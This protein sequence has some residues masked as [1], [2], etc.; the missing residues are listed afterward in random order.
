MASES[1]TPVPGAVMA[2]RIA[3]DR[4]HVAFVKSIAGPREII[5][6]H[7]NWHGR[8]EVAV[9]VP[10]IDVSPANDW[11]QVR[12]FWVESGQMGARTY[13]VEGFILPFRSFAA[14]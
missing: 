8:G 4:G 9:D 3:G 14:G 10:V 1:F 7:A 5:I 11:S 13:P 12:V 6:D 2:L